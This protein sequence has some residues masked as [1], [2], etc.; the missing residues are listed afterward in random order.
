MSTKFY[1]NSETCASAGDGPS[2]L[3]LAEGAVMDGNNLAT[4]FCP[5]CGK[6]MKQLPPDQR[7]SENSQ[8]FYCHNEACSIHC[9]AIFYIYLPYYSI[10]YTNNI[11]S[12]FCPKCNKEMKP[13]AHESCP[14]ISF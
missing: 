1:C 10:I 3:E 8:R 4:I 5:R 2:V 7:E 13:F 9:K 14:V 11:S 6:S 12:I